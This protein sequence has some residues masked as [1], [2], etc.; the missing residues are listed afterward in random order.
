[1]AV[2]LIRQS[3]GP[4]GNELDSLMLARYGE[5]DGQGKL[6]AFNSPDGPSFSDVLDILNPLQHIPV[7]NVVY[8]AVTGDR[9]G[10]ASEVL[11]GVLWGGPI[12]LVSAMVDLAVED[13]TGKTIGAN[14]ASLFSDPAATEAP[15]T[16][17]A[18]SAAASE[19]PAQTAASPTPPAVEVTAVPPEAPAKDEPVSAGDYLI[20]GTAP[21][22][23]ATSTAV[24]AKPPSP[25]PVA[26]TPAD[27]MVFGADS[28]PTSL[29]P[30]DNPPPAQDHRFRPVPA[31]TGPAEPRATLPM[32]TT[33]AA[34]VQSAVSQN[35][36]IG[37]FNAAF[38]KYQ[39]AAKLGDPPTTDTIQ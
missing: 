6:T 9:Q 10:A 39:R 2:E 11:G 38:D 8:Q 28:K 32:P 20:F 31:R 7:I 36:F 13:G 17:L 19:E 21:A 34:A 26:A 16:L 25:T 23:A 33:G 37:N 5:D 1:M 27:F 3:S 24:Q 30:G 14:V 18:A 4:I 15:A 35:Q 22:H 12:G 29:L